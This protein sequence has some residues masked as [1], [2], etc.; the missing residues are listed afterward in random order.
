VARIDGII[1]QQREIDGAA[2]EKMWQ[3][4]I[5]KLQAE[6]EAEVA[7]PEECLREEI[8]RLQIHHT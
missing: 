2:V 8:A 4:E 7:R 5:A 6:K 3:T 1:S